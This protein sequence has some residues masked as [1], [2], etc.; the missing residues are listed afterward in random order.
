MKSSSMVLS[1]SSSASRPSRRAFSAKPTSS[2]TRARMS[3]TWAL[4]A[5][6]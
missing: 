5:F 1:W 2:A 3:S 4:N 6:M